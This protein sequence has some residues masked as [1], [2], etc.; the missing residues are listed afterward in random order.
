MGEVMS[1]LSTNVLLFFLSIGLIVAGC[2]DDNPST[3]ENHDPVIQSVTAN[4]ATI[5]TDGI[6]NVSCVATDSDQDEMTYTWTSQLGSFP[7]GNTGSSVQWQAPSDPGNYSIS[8][9]VS[10]GA[11]TDQDFVN[12]TVE[13][14]TATISNPIPPDGATDVPTTTNLSWSHSGPNNSSYDIYFGTN[15]SPD[16]TELVSSDQAEST[17]DPG[18]L[19]N[20]TT[21]YW[22][23]VARDNRDQETKGSIWSFTT[24]GPENEPPIAPFNPT[25]SD[26]ASDVAIVTDLSWSCSDPDDDTLT[27]RCLVS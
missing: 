6:T 8:V 21:Y 23:I 19:E 26:E 18:V 14:S 12:V 22:K 2:G 10:D 3:P 5:S 13:I 9:T 17:Y 1:N 20:S 4:P 7:D 27:S 16:T 25:P 24:V 15:S 11:E